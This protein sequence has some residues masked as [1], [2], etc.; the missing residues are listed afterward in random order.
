MLF[1]FGEILDNSR[2]NVA[3]AVSTFGHPIGE[4]MSWQYPT[5]PIREVV[6]EFRYLEDGHWDGAGPGLV[7]SA[8]STE[9][10]R[11]L[12]DERPAS[13]AAPAVESPSLLPLG[14][15]QLGLRFIPQRPLRFWREGDESGFIAVA[16]YRLGVHHF[17]PYPSW[18]RF[19]EIIGKGAQAYQDVLKPT[20]VQRI[21]LR[22]I[23]DI[24]LGHM[25]VS[26]EE[27][28]DFYPFVG[29]N[30]PQN[31]SRFHCL[32]QIDFEDA[33]DSLTLQVASAPQ[34]EGQNAQVILD[35]DYFLA[36][37]DN[38]E[39]TETTQWL[40]KAHANLQSVFEGCLKDSARALFR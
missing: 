21:G 1:C 6:C 31:L 11:R 17:R 25:S 12:A 22:Y 19:S 3:T 23:N 5:P 10:P 24:N 13:S 32:V 18:E 30:I 37:P 20:K 8:M 35:L 40:E 28:F 4:P 2:Y 38:F 26:V 27:F 39:L 15:Q 36:Q 29:H 33:R 16:P 9:F 14:L 34:P 7:Y